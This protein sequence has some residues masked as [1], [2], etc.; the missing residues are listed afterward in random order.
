MNKKTKQIIGAV[1]ALVAVF[2]GIFLSQKLT[3]EKEEKDITIQIMVEG[4]EIYNETVDTDAT[5]LADL[6]IEMQTE[7]EIQLDYE[8]TSWGMY[9]KGLGCD[10]LYMED[11]ASGKYWTY[12][13]ENNASCVANNYCDGAD[14]LNIS[15]GD[16]FVFTLEAYE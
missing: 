15:D 2:G 14:L 16:I 7:E 13:S 6:L 4:S 10:E 9:I 5:T 12:N 1:I 8:T 3:E 11:P